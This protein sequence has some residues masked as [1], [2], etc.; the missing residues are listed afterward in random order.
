VEK[1]LW[2]VFTSAL[3]HTNILGS[4]GDVVSVGAFGKRI[5]VVNSAQA[6]SEIFEKRGAIYSERPHNV[7]IQD[8]C[9]YWLQAEG[10]IADAEA[11]VVQ[12]GHI[13]RFFYRK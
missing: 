3:V 4:A 2:F 6:A 8:M 1:D 13:G 11:S 12:H 9:V 10:L 7:M 5:V